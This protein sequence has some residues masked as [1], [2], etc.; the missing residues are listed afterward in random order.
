MPE[1]TFRHTRSTG[2]RLTYDV[3]VLS[4]R[5]TISL[6]GEVLK[7]ALRPSIL[8]GNVA[9]DDATAVFAIADIEQLVDMSEQ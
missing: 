6:N 9:D 4:N 7:D 2:Q 3:R 1:K 8:G 5:Y